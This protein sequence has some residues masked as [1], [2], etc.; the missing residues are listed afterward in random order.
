MPREPYYGDR[1]EN[2]TPPDFNQFGDEL[3]EIA[4]VFRDDAIVSIDRLEIF[5]LFL[6]LKLWDE[7]EL[8]Y[9]EEVGSL[10]EDEQLIPDKYRFH[11]WANDPDTY[12]KQLGFDDSI[13]FC[14]Q[15]FE[16]LANRRSKHQVAGDLR[17]LFKDTIFPLRSSP[18]L[19]ALAS[20]LAELNLRQ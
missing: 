8:E 2:W 6:F 3:W 17:R 4:N 18:T 9:E 1:S 20:K 15:M 5:S 16:D 7:I 10:P 12:A 11:K 14:R 19:R 13:A